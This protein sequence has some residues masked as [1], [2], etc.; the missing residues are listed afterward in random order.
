MLER[1]T[2]AAREVVVAST[3]EAARLGHEQ[4]GSEHLLISLAGG[5]SGLSGRVLT[6]FGLD[7]PHLR[8]ALVGRRPATSGLTD[9]DGEALAS[10][11]VDLHAVRERVEANFGPGALAGET[12]R[13][14]PRFTKDAKKALE[15]A[16]REAVWLK[17]GARLEASAGPLDDRDIRSA[18]RV[19]PGRL[20]LTGIG[21][22]HLL[23]GV[24]RGGG[25]ACTLMLDLDVQPINVRAELLRTLAEAA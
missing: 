22:E 10:I 21:T 13:R 6:G 20:N 23:L 18:L 3:A 17:S 25:L 14:R 15:L 16:L 4:V 2:E 5:S 19:G 1:F 9:E 11:G 7:Q 12:S 24:I 8:T